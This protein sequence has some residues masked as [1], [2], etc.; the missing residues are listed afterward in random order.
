LVVQG[1]IGRS[2]DRYEK[3]R[4][5][6]L[7][8]AAGLLNQKGVRGL[9]LA[10]AASAVGLSTTSVTYYFKRKDDLAA[11]T[12]LR[13]I[14]RLMD[15]TNE[16][17]AEPSPEAQLRA[18]VRL[19]VELQLAEV[20]GRA[21][22]SPS[23]A[24]LRALRAQLFEEVFGGYLKLFRRVR[25]IFEAPELN[26]P[27][28]AATAR[29]HLVLEELFWAAVWLR[30]WAPSDYRYAPDWICDVLIKGVARRGREWAPTPMSAS[31]FIPEPSETH[32]RETFLRAATRLINHQG[33]RGA[34]V[35]AIA[36][37]LGVTKGSFYHHLDAK[38]D[39]VAASFAR[40][41]DVADRVR[42]AAE[43][44]PGDGWDHVSSAA[45]A[46]TELQLSDRGP[47]LRSTA[48]TAVPEELRAATLDRSDRIMKGYAAMFEAGAADGSMRRVNSELGATMLA[49]A[50][51]AAADLGGWIPGLKPRAAPAV[52]IRP[53][54]MGILEP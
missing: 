23:F 17:L 5:A 13:G 49:A 16:A 39:L 14:R 46:I 15:L 51:N 32:N 44:L 6:I 31:R 10:D 37:E 2:T 7:D 20:E 36:A 25:R 54:L 24:D 9:T 48:I 41:L 18:L 53:L 45:A 52:F 34:S 22:P 1:N 33:Y 19:Y 12:M 40:T 28:A 50:L 29:T 8:A 3:K 26:L 30:T 27:R 35:E 42:E 38:D 43:S 11:A 47:L 21:A 4:A